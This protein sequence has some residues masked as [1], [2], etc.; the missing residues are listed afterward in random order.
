MSQLLIP[1]GLRFMEYAMIHWVL[2][3]IK[4]RILSGEPSGLVIDQGIREVMELA[5]QGKLS[6]EGSG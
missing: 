3:G 4:A 1:A 2:Q 5:T 6:E